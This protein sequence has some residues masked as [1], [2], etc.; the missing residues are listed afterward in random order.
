MGATREIRNRET[1]QT[2][3]AKRKRSSKA[4]TVIAVIVLVI[5]AGIVAYP[6]ISDWWNSYH[7]TRAIATYVTAVQE[8]SPEQIEKMLADAHDYNTRLAT[9]PDR[10]TM[11]DADKAEYA[12]LL[13]L[14]GDGV[15]GY[16]QVNCVGIN[17]PIYH[18]MEENVLQIAIG[19]LEGT[20][21]PVGGPTTHA[22]ISGHRGLPSA[23]LF[24]D[25][26]RVTE[27]DTFTV[28]VLNQT[29]AYEVDQISVVLPNDLSNLDIAAD[30]DYCTLVTCTP[31]GVNSHRLLVRGH[32]VDN[33]IDVEAITADAIQIPRYIAIPAVAIP[34][35][36]VFLLAMLISYRLRRPTAS[37]EQAKG[38]V[39]EHVSHS[40]KD[41]T[42]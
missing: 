38:Q 16:V 24:T 25:L 6:T 3:G 41:K 1:T 10:Y 7:Q 33:L 37:N 14:T 9:K 15:M 40:N 39:R 2:A 30:K 8:T 11:S 31:Y 32:R 35:L 29:I 26:D 42:F 19:H 34:I 36:F 13:N 12:S 5:G 27:G 28:T 20:S 22:V 17:Y 21:L 23:K 18:G 4:P